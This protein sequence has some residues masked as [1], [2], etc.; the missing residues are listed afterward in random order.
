MV[1]IS[2]GATATSTW[3]RMRFLPSRKP[4]F[5]AAISGSATLFALLID[6]IGTE[7]FYFER[8]LADREAGA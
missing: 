8:R 5:E 7:A 3:S 6:T 1:T 4:S 2:D